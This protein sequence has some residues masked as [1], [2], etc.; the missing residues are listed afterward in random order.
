MVQLTRF[1]WASAHKLWKLRCEEVHKGEDNIRRR[2]AQKKMKAIYEKKN[3]LMLIDRRF[4][5]KPLNTELV[6]NTYNLEAWI[7]TVGP[8][9]TAGE[10]QAIKRHKMHMCVIFAFTSSAQEQGWDK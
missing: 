10:R 1:I 3:S 5:D 9:V 4:F 8:I 7:T 6:E 2:E